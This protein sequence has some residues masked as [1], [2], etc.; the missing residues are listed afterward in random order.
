MFSV[1]CLAVSCL[2]ASLPRPFTESV[3]AMLPVLQHCALWSHMY[4]SCFHPVEIAVGAPGIKDEDEDED[5]EEEED[6]LS[7]DVGGACPHR[8]TLHV[9]GWATVHIHL[10]AELAGHASSSSPSSST[11]SNGNDATVRIERLASAS[12]STSSIAPAA[13]SSS[14]AGSARNRG[15]ACS[16]AF[17][18][19]ALRRA[20]FSLPLLLHYL[21]R[22][23]S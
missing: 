4:Q 13:V 22:A 1:S 18:T 2:A 19:R 15:H 17:A 3:P 7:V 11:F 10:G 8:L 20:Q 16:D 12:S 6:A 14:G 23:D 21:L 9:A 5:E